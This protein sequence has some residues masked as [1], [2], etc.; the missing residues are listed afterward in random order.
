[1]RCLLSEVLEFEKNI[2]NYTNEEKRN[3]IDSLR[4]DINERKNRL[5]NPFSPKAYNDPIKKSSVS[6]QKKE[7]KPIV[8]YRFINNYAVA[9]K[10]IL[11]HH[12]NN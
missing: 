4:N 3:I 1:M 7:I 2:D 12:Q 9:E 5:S 11:N 6:G 10:F 8:K